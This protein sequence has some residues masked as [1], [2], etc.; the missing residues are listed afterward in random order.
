MTPDPPNL[1]AE[2]RDLCPMALDDGFLDRL[3]AAVD[4]T[5]TE[6]TPEQIRFEAELRAHVPAG[7][8]PELMASLEA[9]VRDVPFPVDE[10]IL[11]FPKFSHQPAAARRE[12]PKWQAAAAVAVI[13]AI[14]A[15]MIPSQKAPEKVAAQPSV[16]APVNP[17]KELRN[18]V[19]AS[20]NRGLSEVHDEGV[21]WKSNNQPQTLVRVVYK[22]QITLTDANGRTVLVEQPRVEYILVP[23]RTD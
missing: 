1:E 23:A 13:G 17:N 3:E 5:L 10:K 2:L 14:S 4:G 20:F 7:L 15:W 16:A 22:D 9:I 18:F 21:I 19:P 11:M 12:W 8:S 6:L